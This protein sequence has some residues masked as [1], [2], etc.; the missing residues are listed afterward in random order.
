MINS[1]A[2]VDPVGVLAPTCAVV[3]SWTNH[4]TVVL[5]SGGGVPISKSSHCAVPELYHWY[6]FPVFTIIAS[7]GVVIAKSLAVASA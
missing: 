1:F 7:V 2:P 6:T 5:A 3:A 4:L